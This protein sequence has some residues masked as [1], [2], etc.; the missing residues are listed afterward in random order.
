M[1][2][3]KTVYYREGR[4]TCP[5]LLIYDKRG[6]VHAVRLGG[7]MVIGREGA[8]TA[9]DIPLSS[10]LASGRHG[11][12]SVKADGVYYQDLGSTNGTYLNKTLFSKNTQMGTPA[13]KLQNGDIIRIEWK[14]KAEYG[15]DMV[16]M[17]YTDS[18][19][20]KSSWVSKRLGDNVEEIHIGRAHSDIQIQ[21]AQ[22]SKNHA[23]FFQAHRGWAIADENSTNGVMLNGIPVSNPQYLSRGDVIRIAD[24]F[25]FYTGESVI[26][27]IVRN[28]ENLVIQIKERSVM[29]KM[30]KV[31]L[32]QDA[33]LTVL[34]GEMVMILGGSGAGKTTF[35]NA[36]MG[37]EKAEGKILYGDK[38]IYTDYEKMKYQIGYVPQQDLLRGSD[39]VF[40]TV[41]DAACLKLPRKIKKAERQARIDKVLDMV[42]LGEQKDRLV[43]K[44]SGG[45]RKRLS[46]AVELIADPSLIFLDEADSGL[47]GKHSEELMENARA[48]A[49]D[50]KIVM[51]ITHSPDR[52]AHLFDKVIVLAK[53]ARDH[54]GHIAFYGG[55]SEAYPFF[56]A[57]S[58]DDVVRAIN[59]K[60]ERNGL[61]M[62]DYYIE[63][64]KKY[65]SDREGR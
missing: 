56:D 10:A 4:G 62:S 6:T 26:Y 2:D 57:K 58:L 29:Q 50:G 45:E 19:E 36:V 9:V 8:S 27:P 13:I 7:D 22:V 21:N 43:S 31:I 24:L 61:E 12:F 60:E 55:I 1:E 48:I 49:N 44:L 39:T 38:D 11:M 35:M 14:D 17:V 34:P 52:V 46:V 40:D 47:D 15:N 23:K 5:T 63:K 28:G 41:N 42:N 33:N 64:Y 59:S 25:F 65:A 51:V 16:V 54:A 37:Y 30:K 3:T 32:L 20:E 18:Y 53:S